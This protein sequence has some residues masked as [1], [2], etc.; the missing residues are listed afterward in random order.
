MPTHSAKP[1]PNRERSALLVIDI[2]ERLTPAMPASVLPG[3]LRNARILIETAR[4]FNLPVI[5]SEQY[6]K[7]LGPTVTEIRE[8]L[9]PET[10]PIEKLSFSCCGE[11]AFAP[12]FEPQGARDWILCGVETHVCVLQTALDLLQRGERVFVAA[13]A[14][15]SRTKAN[16][17]A[18]LNLMQQAGAVIGTTEIFAFALLGA[19]GSE[20]FKKISRLVK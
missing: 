7:G 2:Q 17:R 14:I 12:V 15:A 18:G 1:L 5:L 6:T 13:D 20:S 8:V 9:P 4:E 3:L 19:A 11:A 16:W 10:Q